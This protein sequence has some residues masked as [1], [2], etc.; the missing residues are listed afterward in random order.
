MAA[1]LLDENIPRSAAVVLVQAGHDVALAAALAG[2]ADDRA[3]L[4]LARDQQ[5]VL[6]TFD[7]DFGDLIY[8][9]GIAAPP[10][11]VYLRM[12]PLDGRLAG[13]LAAAALQEEVAGQFVVCSRD[14]VRRRPLPAG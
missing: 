4:A 9:H 1:L 12:D 11:V 13:T 3:V 7:A 6:V 5:R 8:R 2:G 14:G 10:A